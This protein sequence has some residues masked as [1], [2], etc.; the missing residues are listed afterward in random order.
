MLRTN[1][2]H[3]PGRFFPSSS[4]PARSPKS[5]NLALISRALLPLLFAALLFAPFALAATAETARGRVEGAVTDPTGAKV[6]GARVSLRD[7]TGVIAYQ[8]RSDDEGHFAIGEVVTGRYTVNVRLPASRN[9]KPQPSKYSLE[10]L[11]TR[12]FN[13]KSPLSQI[14]CLSPQL[15]RSLRSGSWQARVR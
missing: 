14:T 13:S 8:A 7:I 1:L 5:G 6:A 15:A 9:R 11:R 3:L 4:Y 2:F 12:M 10:R